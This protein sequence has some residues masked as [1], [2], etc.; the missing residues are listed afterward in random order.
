MLVLFFVN[1]IFFGFV[2]VFILEAVVVFLAVV[3]VVLFFSFVF[4][5]FILRPLSF[6]LFLCNFLLFLS[7]SILV[8]F[9]R[10]FFFHCGYRFGHFRVTVVL[11]V[12]LVLVFVV[13]LVV[14]LH[15]FCHVIVFGPHGHC[16]HGL[17]DGI[18][19]V[20]HNFL[21]WN[22]W[23]SWLLSLFSSTRFFSILVFT[24]VVVCDRGH[25]GRCG[26]HGDGICSCMAFVLVVVVV[27]MEVLFVLLVFSLFVLLYWWW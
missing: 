11:V 24:V 4:L 8:C 19:H 13:F 3:V 14:F 27:L 22:L 25:H 2:F 15:F 7:M 10:R 20:Y 1:L 12:M 21:S 23:W 6:I 5:S 17:C 18:L 26:G 16:L 9:C